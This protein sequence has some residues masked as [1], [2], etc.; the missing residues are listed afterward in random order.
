M[1]FF[2]SSPARLTSSYSEVAA[3]IEAVV[4]SASLTYKP[5]SKASSSV[6]CK[7]SNN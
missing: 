5:A 3:N 6:D 4:K 2:L 7:P 1:A